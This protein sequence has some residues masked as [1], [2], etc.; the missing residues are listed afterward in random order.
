MTRDMLKELLTLRMSVDQNQWRAR[1]MLQWAAQLALVLNSTQ[2]WSQGQ[3]RKTWT[4]ERTTFLQGELTKAPRASHSEVAVSR[5][6]GWLNVPSTNLAE[7]VPEETE[8]DARTLYHDWDE[9]GARVKLFRKSVLES[10][11]YDWG[12]RR[13]E[14]SL[15]WRQSTTV[16]GAFSAR[17]TH[18]RQ[19][20]GC[21]RTPFSL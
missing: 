18:Q 12:R 14:G 13:I 19:R 1:C 10:K 17:Q 20:Q 16:A 5:Q 11:T 3:K 15:A 2:F 8:D 4:H 21:S 7:A 9:H 6:E